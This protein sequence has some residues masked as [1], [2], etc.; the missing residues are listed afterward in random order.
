MLDP[1]DTPQTRCRA[2][3]ARGDIT[4]PVG[5]YHRMWGAAVHD[6]ATG[7]HRPLLADVLWLE[8]LAGGRARGQLIVALDHCIL[9][10]AEV[11]RIS[12]AICRAS[13]IAP[14]QVQVT[15]SHTHAAGLM[16]RSRAGFPGG[17][18]IGPY[19]DS[20][21]DRLA[22]LAPVAMHQARSA[23]ILYASGRC[24]LAAHR[25]A[26]DER[27]GQFVCGLNPDGP[28]DHT[29][30]V[31]RIVADG[32]GPIATV[33]NYACHPTTLA[34]DN[35]AI[36]PDYVGAL[37][38]TVE[39]HSG[40]PCLFL[41]G[42]SGDLGPR[43]GFVGDLAVADRNGRRLGFASLA[44]VE[45]LP[46]PGTRYVYG[47]PTISGA[48]IG[49][50]RH[51]PLEERVLQSQTGWHCQNWTLDLPYRADLPSAE[52]VQT[53]LIHWQAEEARAREAG[54]LF[55]ARDC[56]A[57]VEQKTRWLTRLG[58]LPPGAAFPL[59]ITLWRLGDA[60]WLFVP[61]E[62]YQTLQTSLRARFPGRPIVV[63]TLTGGWLPGYVPTTATY[64]KGI[65]QESIALIAP[66][67]A[68]S[69]VGEIAS[70]LGNEMEQAKK[71]RG[72]LG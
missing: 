32:G 46:P 67:C 53:Q 18:L 17:D 51:E 39:R 25:D 65:Y 42:A 20:V 56:R 72:D 70:R 13:R 49:V 63:V 8:P 10:T 26:W 6:R 50:W 41:Q 11:D 59:E 48:V 62:H 7:V 21:A 29:V 14:P 23:K 22:E 16:L 47:G 33:V 12:A 9:D 55:A 45:S 58:E 34:W 1:I 52:E 66:G 69:L 37:R 57:M 2:G 38:E 60:V 71:H 54:D 31:A 40:A 64:G 19:L 3:F 36:S 44:A 35:T 24:D 27:T 15:T 30:L 4:P 68:E 5:I 43:E 61:G 28:A